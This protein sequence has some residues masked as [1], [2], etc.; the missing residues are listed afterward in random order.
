MPTPAHT[1]ILNAVGARLALITTANGYTFSAVSIDRQVTSNFSDDG[2]LPAIKYWSDEATTVRQTYGKEQH[3]LGVIIEV[4]DIL[5]IETNAPPDKASALA[6]DIIAAVNRSV[7][8]PLVAD[9]V[10]ENLGGI[11]QTFALKEFSYNV[12]QGQSPYIHAAL[13]FDAVYL[14]PIGDPFTVEA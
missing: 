9:A 8:A 5:D 7:A 12:G 11:V 10:S 13:L 2:D 3:T 4:F 1:T 14:A 6:S